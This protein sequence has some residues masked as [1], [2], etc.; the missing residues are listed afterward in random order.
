MGMRSSRKNDTP[1]KCE[2]R[3]SRRI[4]P[5]GSFYIP[6][7][8]T[9]EG[10]RNAYAF[11][12][13]GSP[14]NISGKKVQVKGVEVKDLPKR[15]D[16]L[17]EAFKKAAQESFNRHEHYPG[18]RPGTATRI[19]IAE[20]EWI[21]KR[22]EE[23][24]SEDLIDIQWVDKDGRDVFMSPKDIAKWKLTG[25]TNIELLLSGEIMARRHDLTE[26]E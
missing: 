9:Q 16:K 18:S 1:T 11:V 23:I 25:R 3:D 4:D 14:V 20:I 2:I 22:I 13:K 17:L 8:Q 26:E 12:N 5:S 10:L 15:G 19:Q 21:A 24:N 6:T 7:I